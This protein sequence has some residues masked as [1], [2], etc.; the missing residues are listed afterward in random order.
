MARRDRIIDVARA[1]YR[2]FGYRPIDTPALEY[3][4]ILLGKGG[5]ESDKQLYRFDDAGGRDIALRFDLTVPLA[6]YVAQHGQELGMPFKAFHV[7][8]VWRGERPQRGRFREFMQCDFDTI[9]TEHVSADIET[10]L[11]IHDVFAALG[12]ERFTVR[13]NNRKVLTGVLEDVGLADDSAAVLRAIDKL[14]KVGAE[15]VT[16]ELADATHASA[17]QI[18]RVMSFAGLQGDPDRLLD[19][20]E[21]LVGKTDSGAVGVAQL[22]AAFDG[23]AA[24]GA[25]M[26]RF[27]LDV[28]IARDL[29]YYTGIVFETVLDDLPEIGSCCSGGRYDDLASLYTKQRLPGVGASLGVDRLLAALDEMEAAAPGS[30]TAD[31]LVVFMSE[32]RRDD[33]LRLAGEVRREGISVELYPEPRRVGAQL[34]Y[35]DRLGHA[36]ALIAGESELEA[37]TVK[38]KL[39]ETGEEQEVR[40]DDVGPAAASLIRG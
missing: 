2:S 24:G 37:G 7:G 30:A 23:F 26:N 8:P 22:R 21:D 38:L 16:E 20:I 17:D 39:M 28:S 40:R 31:V 6:R 29:D 27:A 9:G 12:F 4:E 5:Q 25:D 11:V 36:L 15:A 33:Y 19:D 10:G 32:D 34:K 35:A 3:S 1:V 14:D 18:E 13:V